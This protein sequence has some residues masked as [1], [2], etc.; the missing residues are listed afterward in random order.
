MKLI[1]IPSHLVS[2]M[3]SALT[4]ILGTLI[5]AL[6]SWII[7]NKNTKKSIEEQYRIMRENIKYEESYKRKKICENANVIRLDISTAM[8]QSVRFLKD[9]FNKNI[10]RQYP[11]P[12]NKSYSCTV[13]SLSDKYSLKE[14]S[15]IYQF[16]AIVEKLNYDIL[17]CDMS[18]EDCIN[19]IAEGYKSVLFKL[20]GDNWT[21]ILEKDIDKASYNEL[22]DNN[23]MKAG[24]K[25]VL[26]KL[27]YLCFIE[28]LNKGDK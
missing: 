7:T 13:S 2:T 10:E 23:Y 11:I 8:F 18:E 21:K 17:N 26:K 19:K 27:D 22:Y 28:N 12:I 3:I 9:Y 24:Y 20:Y 4:I 16:Y 5:G 6:C 15:Y 1:T 25:E 14:L